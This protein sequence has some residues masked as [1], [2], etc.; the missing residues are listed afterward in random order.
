MRL[1]PPI[2]EK[3]KIKYE[4]LLYQMNSSL[5]YIQTTDDLCL[6]NIPAIENSIIIDFQ[7]NSQNDQFILNS[8]ISNSEKIIKIRENAFIKLK[9]KLS[10]YKNL[11]ENE[12]NYN[13]DYSVT[14]QAINILNN[15]EECDKILYN[16][17]YI[18]R[19]TKILFILKNSLTDK[20]LYLQCSHLEQI[21]DEIR[22]NIV[23]LPKKG[24]VFFLK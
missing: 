24:Y 5:N 9:K 8:A 6:L 22:T 15:K 3:L 18:N 16:I 20:K 13:N 12:E 17:E 2:M 1:I 19:I 4:D 21:D 23:G 7:V 10:I 14:T 11:F